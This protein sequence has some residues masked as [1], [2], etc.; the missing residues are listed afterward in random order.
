[1]KEDFLFKINEVLIK[2]G[3]KIHMIYSLI[4]DF[5]NDFDG[6]DYSFEEGV[7]VPESNKIKEKYTIEN[8]KEDPII[9]TFRKFYWSKLKIDPTKIRPSGEAL[10]RRVLQGK[11]LPKINY[12]VDAY[13]W[14]SAVSLIPIGAYDADKINGVVELRKAKEGEEF[15]A[16]GG[17]V[18]KM[19]GNELI[20]ID[21]S[22]QILSQF[23]YRDAELTKVTR[24]TKNIFITCLGVEG[25]PKDALYNAYNLI[26][27]FLKKGK[28]KGIEN[29]K[30]EIKTIDPVYISNF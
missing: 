13:N 21:E 5:N 16:I 9:A 6:A 12:F 19:K 26:I 27:K 10:V 4:K 22:G 1:M 18:R 25:V 2:D 3:F 28:L 20:T 15:L 17:K 30:M 8:I 23:P 11:K 24:A 7:I 29:K 14:A